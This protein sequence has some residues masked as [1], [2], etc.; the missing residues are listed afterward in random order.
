MPSSGIVGSY[1]SSIP[2]F[3]SN[4]HTGHH[5]GCI[6]LH[7]HPHCKRLDGH[8]DGCEVIPHCSIDFLFSSNER[9]CVSFHV[10]FGYPC[11]W[12]IVCLG[13]LP[14]SWLGCLLF[15]YWAVWADC[16]FWRLILCQLLHLVTFPSMT[17][18]CRT[19]PISSAVTV[20]HSERPLFPLFMVS[21]PAVHLL[22]GFYAQYTSPTPPTPLERSVFTCSLKYYVAYSLYTFNLCI[23]FPGI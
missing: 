15:W 6:N 17:I 22:K 1:G 21:F 4:L 19:R 14:I 23:S 18:P 7:S 3:S 13:F 5:S 11:L 16:I 2:S 12:R 20:S 8:S 9:C 10:F